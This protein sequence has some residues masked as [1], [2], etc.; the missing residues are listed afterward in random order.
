MPVDELT[1]VSQDEAARYADDGRVVKGSSPFENRV[2]AACGGV[3]RASDAGPNGLSSFA[4]AIVV[5]NLARDLRRGGIR[6]VRVHHRDSH[7]RSIRLQAYS[8]YTGSFSMPTNCFPA[9]SVATPV[10]P[11]PMNGSM[12]I[13]ARID[14][15]M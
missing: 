14:W 15:Q 11:L 4:V 9:R 5:G 13:L 2:V 1:V 7:A 3:S 6:R 8:K 12:M 10:V